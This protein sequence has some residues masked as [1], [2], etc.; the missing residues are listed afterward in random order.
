[1]QQTK[2]RKK[3]EKKENENSKMLKKQIIPNLLK[4]KKNE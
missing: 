3:T 1:M 2:K 4:E